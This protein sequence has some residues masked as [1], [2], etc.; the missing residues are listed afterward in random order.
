MVGG[1]KPVVRAEVCVVLRHRQ[2]LQRPGATAGDSG[3]CRWAKERSFE[4]S[5][6]EHTGTTLAVTELAEPTEQEVCMILND[7]NYEC[8]LYLAR[9]VK[10]TME[11]LI[12]RLFGMP[13][14]MPF[15]LE[16]AGDLRSNSRA[17]KKSSTS[18]LAH[19]IYEGNCSN[20]LQSR[21]SMGTG[22]YILYVWYPP[23][24]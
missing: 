21:P 13:F 24:K 16:N 11:T 18:C 20:S 15:V 19:T 2:P 1:P 8:Y 3:S 4:A 17:P 22:I 10:I 5:R 12:V 9:T 7:M 23:K 14:W 6:Q